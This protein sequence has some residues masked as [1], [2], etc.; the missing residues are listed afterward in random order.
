MSN[1]ESA[2]E[3]YETL[4]E[5][6]RLDAALQA[7]DQLQAH[8]KRTGD[9]ASREAVQCTIDPLLERAHELRDI[10]LPAEEGS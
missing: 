2:R 4:T 5:Y 9:A 10:L 1:L 8:Y 7:L 6:N 3:F